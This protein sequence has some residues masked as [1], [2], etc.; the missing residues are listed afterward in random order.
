MRDNGLP[1]AHHIM[2]EYLQD[3][4]IEKRIKAEGFE[5]VRA[6][7][8]EELQDFPITQTK[9]EELVKQLQRDNPNKFMIDLANY[10]FGGYGQSNRKMGW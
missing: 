4:K 5:K 2:K 8:I 9:K 3:S 1:F 7:V 6:S 10:A